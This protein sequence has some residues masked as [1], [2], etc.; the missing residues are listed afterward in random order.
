[1]GPRRLICFGKHKTPAPRL[2][3][4]SAIG[5]CRISA[6]L[7]SSTRVR[8]VPEWKELPFIILTTESERDKVMEAVKAG[9]TNY[10]VKPIEE[11]MLKEKLQR[12]WE[13]MHAK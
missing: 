5:T 1:M 8:M 2:I 7:I 4:S 3:S 10:L 13:K 6:G 12:V 11:D 9:A